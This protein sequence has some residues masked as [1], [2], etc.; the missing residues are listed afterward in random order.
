MTLLGRNM[1]YHVHLIAFK[2]FY[3]FLFALLR[4]I[5]GFFS[6]DSLPLENCL[7]VYQVGFSRASRLTKGCTGKFV[8]D[9]ASNKCRWRAIPPAGKS[10]RPKTRHNSIPHFYCSPEALEES[11]ASSPRSLLDQALGWVFS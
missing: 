1:P 4:C 7:L 10:S 6:F 8:G 9:C 5:I 2:R 3:K 11:N